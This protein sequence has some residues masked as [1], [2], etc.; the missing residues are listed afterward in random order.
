METASLEERVEMLSRV[1]EVMCVLE[2]LNNFT[3]VVAFNSALNFSSVL[4]LKK[5]QAVGGPH[6]PPTL[7]LPFSA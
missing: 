2:E 3:G 6:S 5:S 4:R 1:L 7:P